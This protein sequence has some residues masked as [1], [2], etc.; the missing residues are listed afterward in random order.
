MKRH[1]IAAML[2]AWYGRERGSVEMLHFLPQ[3]AKIS[4]VAGKL[5]GRLFPPGHMDFIE[6]AE[7][8]PVI[9]GQDI[10]KRTVISHFEAG[11]LYVEVSHP[12]WRAQFSSPA[13]KKLLLSKIEA[14]LGRKLCKDIRF[15]PSGRNASP[16]APQ[17]PRQA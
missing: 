12:A 17:A 4:D 16:D 14:H 1:P 11:V 10:A 7:N 5:A 2:K 15:I 9:A 3:T 6:I 8:W 13:L